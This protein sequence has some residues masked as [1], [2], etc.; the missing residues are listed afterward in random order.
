MKINLEINIDECVIDDMYNN[1][2]GEYE[3]CNCPMVIMPNEVDTYK[4]CKEKY[5]SIMLETD[6]EYEVN[7]MFR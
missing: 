1:T 6:L 5:I 7:Q 4:N 2:C 3:C